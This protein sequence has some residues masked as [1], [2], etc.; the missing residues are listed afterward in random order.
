M[1]GVNKVLENSIK[2]SKRHN[3]VIRGYEPKCKV[4][5]SNYQKEVEHMYELNHP[6]RDIKVYMEDNGESVSLM[7]ISRHFRL[8]YPKR[9]AYFDNVKLMEDECIQEA[10][11]ICPKLEDIF[12]DTEKELDYDK[13][14]LNED[15]T[16][17][18]EYIWK[19][20]SLSDVFLNDMGYC[21]TEYRFCS[22]IPKREVLCMEDVV[23]H[24]NVEL[25]KLGNSYS[26]DGSK[27]FSLL[28]Q[29]SKCLECKDFNNT[30]RI[31]YMMYLLL[32]NFF[33]INVESEKLNEFLNL[34]FDELLF[35]DEVDYNFNK[36]DVQLKKLTKKILKN[37]L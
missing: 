37:I 36:M 2:M 17:F 32:K 7:S 3:N 6:Y 15:K 18:E 16:G 12:H 35:S 19:E 9:K 4:C 14:V 24:S 27:R 8:H 22:N 10:I 31:E 23:S 25:M 21:L 26:F 11:K 33:N 30:A 29:K 34:T 13:M 20:Q 28:N 1:K 5:N